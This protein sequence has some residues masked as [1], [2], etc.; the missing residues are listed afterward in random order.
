MAKLKII[1]LIVIVVIL[2]VG[3][4]FLFGNYSDGYRAGTMIKFSKR[5]VL[6]KTYEGEL[7]LGM[8]LNEQQPSVSVSNIW[9]FSVKGSEDELK[10]KLQN[11]LLNGKRVKVHYNEKF[12][13]FDWRGDTKY[14]V[15]EVEILD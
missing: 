12:F 14:I 13:Q 2:G 5:G 4:Y 7:N 6:F 3:G 1:G 9:K 15:D 10:S 11:A 8:V